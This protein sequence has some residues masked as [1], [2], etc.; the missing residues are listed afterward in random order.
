[1]V[2]ALHSGPAPSPEEPTRLAREARSLRRTDFGC[3]VSVTVAEASMALLDGETATGRIGASMRG[4]EVGLMPLATAAFCAKVRTGQHFAEN[5][6]TPTR[7][8]VRPIGSQV[9]S[10]RRIDIKSARLGGLPEA[11]VVDEHDPDI[12]AECHRRGEMDRVKRSK[13]RWV[14]FASSIQKRL[15]DANHV[16]RSE[17]PP[18]LGDVVL[19]A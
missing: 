7:C 6:I 12:G 1:V 10:T 4:R 9:P 18:G 19:I 16:H 17:K 13:I 8:R 2:L 3:G 5:S 15:V 14:E 11:G